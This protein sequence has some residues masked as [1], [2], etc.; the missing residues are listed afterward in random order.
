MVAIQNAPLNRLILGCS[1]LDLVRELMKQ[2]KFRLPFICD[3]LFGFLVSGEK[4]VFL[5]VLGMLKKALGLDCAIDEILIKGAAFP[6]KLHD[7]VKLSDALELFK[8]LVLNSGLVKPERADAFQAI[9][10]THPTVA[11]AFCFEG[12]EKTCKKGT[13]CTFSHVF[14]GSTDP[15]LHC[16]GGGAAAPTTPARRVIFPLTE[17]S[18]R[19]VPCWNH[20]TDQGCTR[21]GCVFDHRLPKGHAKAET[22][23]CTSKTCINPLCCGMHG[24]DCPNLPAPKQTKR[25]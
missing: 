12:S 18:R 3:F 17:L 21:P 19:G 23:N 16:G 6:E 22:P 7:Q 4:E 25:K 2:E 5:R 10:L 24:L 14:L 9:A 8:H 15:N 13:D 20:Q 1:I 11:C